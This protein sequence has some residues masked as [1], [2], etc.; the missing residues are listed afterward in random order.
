MIHS[1]SWVTGR[2]RRVE[3]TTVHF[4]AKWVTE[5]LSPSFRWELEENSVLSL[6]LDSSWR[7]KIIHFTLVLP[8]IIILLLLWAASHFSH[9]CTLVC[10]SLSWNGSIMV[11]S[12]HHR[13]HSN[14]TSHFIVTSISPF[15]SLSYVFLYISL[16]FDLSMMMMFHRSFCRSKML[17]ASFD[18]YY[19][20]QSYKQRCRK[21]TRYDASILTSGAS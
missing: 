19:F 15:D 16:L 4:P 10:Y 7:R 20:Q 18:G 2:W 9:F 5:S 17:S 11:P 1:L 21:K 12:N 13:D 3:Q 6:Q 8:L 14:S